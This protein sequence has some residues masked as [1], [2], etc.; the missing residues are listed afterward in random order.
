[1]KAVEKIREM[2]KGVYPDAEVNA[3]EIWKG[4]SSST[5]R[6]GWHI[7]QFGELAQFAGK[8][9]EEVENYLQEI[10]EGRYE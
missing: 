3:M 4:Y 10:K 7:R 2:L 9:V 1:M 8:S 5:E 6:T